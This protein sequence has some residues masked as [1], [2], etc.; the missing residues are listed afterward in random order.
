[1]AESCGDCGRPRSRNGCET[2][3][4]SRS[5]PWPITTL[6]LGEG[7]GAP[8]RKRTTSK[9]GTR[10]FQ[11]SIKLSEHEAAKVKAIAV[12]R[13]HTL[14]Q[15]IR[16]LIEDGWRYRRGASAGISEERRAEL[17]ELSRPGNERQRP[18]ER[19]RPVMPE[20]AG[21]GFYADVAGR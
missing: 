18:P 4:R 16:D 20:D 13:G 15:T 14:G 17:R 21:G 6:V 5:A 7:K 10:R 2:C 19:L 3:G 1:M 9:H 11:L 8:G 12:E